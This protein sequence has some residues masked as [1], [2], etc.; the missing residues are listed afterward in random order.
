[1][2]TS[3]LYRRWKMFFYDL[4]ENPQSRLK[5]WFDFFMIV[6]V[7]TS[8]VLLIYGEKKDV[9]RF[10]QLFEN[11][12]VIFFIAEYLL[13]AW[14]YS[15]CHKVV[16]E[17][18]ERAQ[19]LGIPFRVT[20]ALGSILKDKWNYCLTP[21]A[22]IDLLAILPS[23]RPLRLLRVFLIF[24]LLK[25]F[26]YS[27]S[28]KIFVEVLN[29]KRFELYTLAIFFGFLIFIASTAIYHFENSQ[30]GGDIHDLYD[31]AY[32]A[33]VTISTVGYGDIYPHT[34][35]GRFVAMMLIISGLGVL[36]FFTSIFVVAFNEKMHV[37]RENRVIAEIEKLEDFI[38]VCG[39][40]KV[41]REI[42]ELLHRDR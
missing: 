35:E 38:I 18:Y 3:G 14:L 24:R 13:R 36:S 9:G 21:V 4:L 20:G 33:V 37:L 5:F 31:A 23:Y 26:R 17:R 15:D 8:V 1:M 25:L 6:V 7:M 11:F 22:I 12:V 27:R 10:G 29:S 39:Y 41:G 28:I 40:G 30:E 42:A 2:K 32:W 16:I 19:Y 34:A